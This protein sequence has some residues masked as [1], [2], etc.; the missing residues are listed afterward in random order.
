MKVY[1]KS[2]SDDWATPPAIFDPL[3]KEFK[4][5]LDVCATAENTKCKRFLGPSMDALALPWRGR[6]FMNPPFSQVAD[7]CKKAFEESRAGRCLVV[8]LLAAR[9]DTRYF[10]DYIYRKTK[11]RFIKGRVKFMGAKWPAP[12]PSIIVIWKRRRVL[13]CFKTLGALA[14]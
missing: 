12:F 1:H 7:F 4:F 2:K 8:G 13:G 10:H 3:N 9:T 6:C 5:T 11:I 14:I